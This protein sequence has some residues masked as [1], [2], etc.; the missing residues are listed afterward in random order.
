MPKGNITELK[1]QELHDTIT[2]NCY[3][4]VNFTKVFL[5]KMR[6]R[7]QKSF[8]GNMS[9]FLSVGACDWLSVYS[10]SKIFCDFISQGLSFELR[11]TGI[12]VACFRP[13]AIEAS[14]KKHPVCLPPKEIA[15]ACLNKANSSI[16]FGA[17]K[18][19]LMGLMVE[20][21]SDLWPGLGDFVATKIAGQKRTLCE[22]AKKSK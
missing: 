10:A 13:A 5:P 6:E 18:H 1:E 12:E 9:A 4:L 17:L 14:N 22:E 11:G 19:E 21:L 16:H 15:E 20:Q 7:K 3:S 2:V 8:I